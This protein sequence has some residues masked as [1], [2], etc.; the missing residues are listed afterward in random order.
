MRFSAIVI[1]DA[2]PASFL[3]TVQDVEAAGVERLWT[4]DHLSWRRVHVSSWYASMP[5]LAAA[6][7]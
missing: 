2:S 3:R 7:P 1:P 6:S 4:Y 5:L